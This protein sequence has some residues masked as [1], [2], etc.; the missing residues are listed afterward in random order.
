MKKSLYLLFLITIFATINACK[1]DTDT[2]T[3][4]V[5]IQGTQIETVTSNSITLTGSDIN[6]E[7]N[8]I[9][10]TGI[11]KA[12]PYGFLRKVISIEKK[13]GKANSIFSITTEPATLEQAVEYSYSDNEQYQTPFEYTFSP[14]DGK[15]ELASDSSATNLEPINISIDKIVTVTS[16]GTNLELHITGD[17]ELKPQLKG[18]M[19]FG[20]TATGAPKFNSAY[21]ILVSDNEL[22][23][24]LVSD[25]DASFAE[26]FQI[27]PTFEVNPFVIFLGPIPVVIR[28]QIKVFVGAEGSLNAN[29]TYHYD[30]ETNLAS[31]IIYLDG[32]GWNTANN[33]GFDVIQENA[34]TSLSA[35]SGNIS[36]YVKPD[37]SLNLYDESVVST[38]I[39]AK[40][41]IAFRSTFSTNEFNWG[42]YG[43]VTSGAY[44]NAN[45][46]GF[47]LDDKEWP[48][49][50]QTPEWLITSGTTSSS[51]TD[52]P[53]T[54]FVAS[55]TNITEGTVINFTDGTLNT[56]T[57]W[58]WTFAGGTPN[59]ST[60]QNPSISYNTAGT[61]DVTLTATNAN[62]N[63][64]ETKTGFITVTS[65]G[66][67]GP[68]ADFTASQTNITEGT[69]IN[70]ADNSTN[71][72]TSW[73]WTFAG[74]TPSS[75]TNQNPSVTYNTAG[76]YDVTLTATNANG[77]D[78]ETKTG[79][80]SVV[81]SAGSF[82]GNVNLTTQSAVNTFGANNYNKIIGNLSIGGGATT[83]NIN[84]L[85][86]LSSLT[87][88]SGNL[89]I[90]LTQN[91]DNLDGLD[92]LNS[93][94]GLSL[95]FNSS[96]EEIDA[97]FNL[98]TIGSN[99]LVIEDHYLLANIN[100]LSNLESVAGDVGISGNDL[101]IDYCGL[102]GIFTGSSFLGTYS[103]NLN[104]FNP[105]F[106]DIINGNCSRV[107]IP[108]AGL[109]D[110]DG[111]NYTSVVIGNQEWMSENLLVTHYSDGTPI[112]NV[113]L[114]TNWDNLTYSDKAICYMNNN[115]A[116]SDYGLLYT[117][118]TVMNGNS[119]SNS[120][121]SGIQGVCPIGW[122]IPSQSE[123]T[124]LINYMGGIQNAGQ[125]LKK[126]GLSNW[127][128]PNTNA[129]NLSQ[130]SAV[131][132]GK[133]GINGT[134]YSFKNNGMYWSSSEYSSSSA[135]LSVMN[136]NNVLIQQGYNSKT[137]GMSC[138]CIK[139]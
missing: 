68:V 62:G 5:V 135:Y 117:W 119:G 81:S 73:S 138:R 96:L 88:I 122:H 91:L 132:G 108:G 40:P 111:N 92:N 26:E 1:K 78:V 25:I 105:T 113:T 17:L 19:Y 46:F 51:S 76:T 115:S 112:S 45:V 77:N 55:Q 28:P 104:A 65:S 67:N 131:G 16:G 18:E 134:F 136:Y 47:G 114:Q 97:L 24:D 36:V 70:F 82:I 128:S 39:Y 38:G 99:G 43:G 125:Y 29:L 110:Y 72:P 32:Q 133:R 57:S 52:L 7:K 2:P 23:V 58:A 63:D 79:F 95:E 100:G 69:S 94:N 53:I 44:F 11:S 14:V 22:N 107:G 85:A 49:V 60:S 93:V 42:L 118:A 101:F 27:G 30:S 87:Y 83:S 37:L 124:E 12:A 71:T 34:S 56:P 74:G 139:D 89:S 137:N 33:S 126:V 129:N 98:D 20:K 120:N 80:I 61:Y 127:N 103:A 48:N 86:P 130:F 64:T 75:S 31:G 13:P 59:S 21:F 9:I 123:W 15:K 116:N 35:V 4:T 109:S 84:N 8:D 6:I 66:G 50:F 54:N 3:K 10:V 106:N 90:H 41:Y 102:Y 121:P